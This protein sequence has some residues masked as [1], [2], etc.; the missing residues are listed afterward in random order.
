MW[1]IATLLLKKKKEPPQKGGNL[2]NSEDNAS[3]VKNR[4]SLSRD[5]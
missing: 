5:D 3:D 1:K 2:E 4:E